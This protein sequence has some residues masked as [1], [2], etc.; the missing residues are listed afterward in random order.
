MSDFYEISPE[1]L[2]KN[3]FNLIG[4]DW[5]LVTAEKDGKV[6]TMTA[7]WGGFGVMWGKNV[8]NIVIR[9]Q[10]FTKEFIDASGTFSLTVL[11]ESFR[12]QLT[13][14]GTVSGRDEDKVSKS[15]LSVVHS[16]DTPYFNE[17]SV[18]IICKKLYAQEYK[19]ECFTD[20][21]IDGKWYPDKDY[22][23]LYIGEITK[24]LIKK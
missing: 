8:A 4:K 10:R 2:D 14:L 19:P 3:I 21:N 16:D 17:A 13:Y 18:A 15:N 1:Q 11:D 5:M 7:S 24:I 23:T 6:N 22:H 20:K 9:P 12:K